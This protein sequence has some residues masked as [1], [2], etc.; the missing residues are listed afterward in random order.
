[1]DAALLIDPAFWTDPRPFA[2]GDERGEL[3]ELPELDGH[4]LF[5]TS[6]STGTPKWISLSK[7]AL[8]L[9]AACVNRHLEVTEASR[10]GAA[11]PFHHVGGFGVAARAF[12]AACECAVFPGRWDAV[13][14]QTWLQDRAITHT[15]LVPTQVHDLVV[16]GLRAPSNLRAIVVGGGRMSE[17][18]GNKARE[19]GWPV[20]ASY[21]MTETGSQIATQSLDILNSPYQHG[22][23]P[24]LDIWD[25]QTNADGILEISGPALFSG[26]LHQ[27]ARGEWIYEKRRS[28]W[29]RTSDRVMLQDRFLTPLGRA[30]Q[31]VKILGELVDP[32]AI[33]RE[34]MALS[35]EK[36]SPGC[37]AVTAVPDERTE[38]R[39]I[40]VFADSITRDLVLNVLR[41]YEIH[42]PGY[43]RLQSPVFVETIPCSSLGKILRSDL[44]KLVER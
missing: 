3:P 39:L 31:I 19:L 14:F 44:R 13:R 27:N 35:A 43:R 4:V 38:H 40:P 2:P 41:D 32:E 22:S 6:G 7:S 25:A 15:S 11:L 28:D 9:S 24:L 36:L 34:L 10:W 26:S 29:H 17:D 42:A 18:T 5:Q 12:E 1:M 8:L 23:I 37:F 16:S 21:G 33:E 20:L 30:D